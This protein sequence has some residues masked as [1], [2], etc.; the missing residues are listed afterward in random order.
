[1]AKEE[2]VMKKPRS[3]NVFMLFTILAATGPGCSG[4]EG[5]R[6]AG[7]DNG[8]EPDA[9]EST[10]EYGDS[11]AGPDSSEDTFNNA[12]SYSFGVHPSSIDNYSHAKK[13]GLDFN[14]E[15]MYVFWDWV[16]VNR[17]GSFRFKDATAPEHPDRPGSG[18][19]V[20]YD[21]ELRQ[22]LNVD[23]I[24]L[25]KNVCPFKRGSL[26]RAEFQNEEQ[27]ETY[28]FFIEK[29]VERYDGDSELGCTQTNGTDCYKP[30]DNEYPDQ[31]LI[32]ILKNNPIKFWQVCNQVTDVC[33][34]PECADDNLYAHN[35]AEV[36]EL[37][38][39]GVKASCPD[40][41]VLIAGDSS[42][43]MYPPVFEILGGE[44]TDIIDYHRFD[45]ADSYDPQEDFNYLKESLQNSGFDVSKLRFWITETGTHSGDPVDDRVTPPEEGPPY[46]SEEQQAQS[47]I[48]RYVAA[49]GYGIEKVLWAWGIHE[50]FGCD[51]CR[52]DY[53]GLIYDGNLEPQSCDENDPYDRG[54]GVKKLAY[55]T[56]IMMT[57]KLKGFTDVET[58]LNSEGTYVYKFIKDN[59]PVYVA[60][61]EN[62]ESASLSGI[63]TSSITIT[64]AVPKYEY[65]EQITD[66]NTAFNTEDKSL[67]DGGVSIALNETPVFVEEK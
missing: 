3:F 46:Q 16:D 41:Q 33:E 28:K 64:E 7:I 55:Y 47:L 29:T 35:Y 34:G 49:F 24:T 43:D 13:L 14:R 42:K 62:G 6:D 23:D 61:S 5:D 54:F 30:G 21:K 56:F 2:E 1:M 32:D 37:T 15:G 67:S 40:C 66:F 48:K 31:E 50:G 12:P 57:H 58:V 8:T 59:K 60:W 63:N 25:M 45:E 27:K 36:M 53:T 4:G 52:F 22:L 38:Y 20:D 44:Y 9:D 18:G 17:D 65:G 51:C 19:T 10:D 26:T 11:D 39:N